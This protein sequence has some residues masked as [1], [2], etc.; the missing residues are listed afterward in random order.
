MGRNA[1]RRRRIVAT[2]LVMTVASGLVGASALAQDEEPVRIGYISGGDADPFV[3][4]VT[5]GIRRAAADAGVELHPGDADVDFSQSDVL[6]AIGLNWAPEKELTFRASYSQTVAHQT[7]KELTPIQQ[8]EYLG[9][10]VFIGNP[11][12]R[13]ETSGGVEAGVGWQAAAREGGTRA[14]AQAVGEGLLREHRPEHP[15]RRGAEQHPQHD[16]RQPCRLECGVEDDAEQRR[17][18]R[19]DDKLAGR[20]QRGERKVADQD[21]C[22]EKTGHRRQAGQANR[23][24]YC[25]N[26]QADQQ[27]DNRRLHR[28]VRQKFLQ[29]ASR[30]A[31]GRRLSGPWR[32]PLSPP[33]S[34]RAARARRSSPDSSPRRGRAFSPSAR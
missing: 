28:R 33:A 10:P 27:R 32:S 17:G 22:G 29:G 1:S 6:P 7:F 15:Q 34:D 12:L 11:D 20:S 16:A 9:G 30:D 2:A 25:R 13:P 8:Q 14:E 23:E 3:L 26:R 5:E 24:Q 31:S 21:D 4:L 19:Y 18:Y